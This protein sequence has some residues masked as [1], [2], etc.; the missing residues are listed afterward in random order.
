V[1]HW[2]ISLVLACMVGTSW[3]A[4][5]TVSD[6]RVSAT[7]VA[8]AI[9][10]SPNA[11]PQLKQYAESIGNLA[12]FESGGRLSVYNGSCCYGVLQ[13]TSSNVKATLGM[14]TEAFRRLP[15]QDQVDAW[16]TL[17]SKAIRDPVV[18]RLAALGT[19]DGR[20]VD[21][22]MVLACVQLGQGNCMNMLLSGRCSGFADINGTTICSMADKIAGGS[23]SLAATTPTVTTG[24]LGLGS[25]G[26][27]AGY[28]GTYTG[29]PKESCITDG[30]GHCASISASIGSGFQ[31]G[32]GVSMGDLRTAIQALTVAGTM[33]IMGGALLG[34]WRGYADGALSQVELVDGMRKACMAI[35]IIAAVITIV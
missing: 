32:S 25:T 6:A 8:Q 30:Y 4:A 34:L 26:P 12:M 22:N 18:G 33:L 27:A 10:N 24:D 17:M 3:G 2:L 15:L 28:G 20:K 16:S 31:T 5:G 7:D 11:S 23:T 14:S 13:L 29:A 9:R 21:G 19:F 35:L 1:V